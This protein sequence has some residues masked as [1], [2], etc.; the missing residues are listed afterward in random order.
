LEN[1]IIEI[2]SDPEKGEDYLRGYTQP[3]STAFGIT[4]G[5]ALYHRAYVKRL[6]HFDVGISVVRL[7]I[8]TSAKSFIWQGEEVPTFFGTDSPPP[9]AVQ[10]TNLSELTIPQIQLNLGLSADFELMIR[11][12]SELNIA[13]IGEITVYGIGVKYGLSDLISLPEFPIDLSVQATYHVLRVSTW[14]K[15]GTFGMN[16]QSSADLA[17]VPIGIYGGLGYEATSMTIKTEEIPGIGDNA[18]GDV[19]LDGENGLRINFGLSYTLFFFTLNLDYNICKY[20]S[21]AGGAKIVF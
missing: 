16:I 6:P 1:N 3:L 5:G 13:E 7:P 18:I 14:L 17:F 12:W 10:G 9:D 2:L 8:P 21:I 20:N 4:S 15:T 11:G 19:K